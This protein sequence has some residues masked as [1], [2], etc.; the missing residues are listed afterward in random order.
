M[1]LPEN[2]A[3]AVC[4]QLFSRKL[5]GALLR[6]FAPD[7]FCAEHHKLALALMRGVHATSLTPALVLF[8]RTHRL[9]I[10]HSPLLIA[11]HSSKLGAKS[12]MLRASDG[13]PPS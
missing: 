2:L 1:L 7:R 3:C 11:D 8:A 10:A 6:L 13:K 5:G 9:T 4:V 12:T